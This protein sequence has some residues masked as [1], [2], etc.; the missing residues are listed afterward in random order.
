MFEFYC[1]YKPIVECLVCFGF[2]SSYVVLVWLFVLFFFVFFMHTKCSIKVSNESFMMFSN[3]KELVIFLKRI[4]HVHILLVF[5]DTCTHIFRYMKKLGVL[6]CSRLNLTSP[7]RYCKS[8]Q[9]C[10]ISNNS[11]KQP[12]PKTN[13]PSLIDEIL[14]FDIDLRMHLCVFMKFKIVVWFEM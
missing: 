14:C 4:E 12:H 11:W 5:L 3:L 9:P 10:S 1:W 13:N 8:Q 7:V 6:V 2:V